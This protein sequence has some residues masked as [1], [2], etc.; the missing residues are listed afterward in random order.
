[1]KKVKAL[2]SFSLIQDSTTIKYGDEWYLEKNLADRLAE[3]NYVEI[4]NEETA[5]V[6]KKTVKRKT[7]KKKDDA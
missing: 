1:M 7:T 3:V 6:P 2:T 4:L 5:E